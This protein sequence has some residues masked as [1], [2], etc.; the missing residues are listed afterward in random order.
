MADREVLS[1][2]ASFSL[3]LGQDAQH[4]ARLLGAVL[5][6]KP[7]DGSHRTSLARQ[8]IDVAGNDS[9]SNSL[10]RD[11]TRGS[12]AGGRASNFVLPA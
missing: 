12:A 6:D 2:S 1:I 5:V 10:Q 9:M 7:S 8:G 3:A 11:F 4:E